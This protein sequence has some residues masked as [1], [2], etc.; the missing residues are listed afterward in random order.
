MKVKHRNQK[1]NSDVVHFLA[2]EYDFEVEAIEDWQLRL[3]ISG[4]KLDYF[5][6]T[7]RATWVGSNK[8]TVIKDI[9]AFLIDKFHEKAN[10]ENM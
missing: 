6:Q 1:W 8:W 7:G 2:G 3:S 10:D 5:P 9:E 4:R